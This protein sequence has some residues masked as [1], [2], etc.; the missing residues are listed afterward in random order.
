M[1]TRK[2]YNVSSSTEDR[3]AS[4]NTNFLLGLPIEL[5]NTC[6]A[7]AKQE[8]RTVTEFMRMAIEARVVKRQAEHAAG[9]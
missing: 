3:P 1:E 2:E 6:R 4:A 9:K 5:L 7:L 8:R